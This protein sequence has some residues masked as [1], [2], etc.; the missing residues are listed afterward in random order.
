MT[1]QLLLCNWPRKLLYTLQTGSCLWSE[2]L[3]ANW[4]PLVVQSRITIRWDKYKNSWY[5]GTIATE[6][7]REY[8]VRHR[9]YNF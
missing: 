8:T 5:R 6:N 9:L 1:N 4:L 2:I 3:T 7:N